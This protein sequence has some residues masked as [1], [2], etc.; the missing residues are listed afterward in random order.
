MQRGAL[1]RPHHRSRSRRHAHPPNGAFAMKRALNEFAGLACSKQAH[2]SVRHDGA[3]GLSM[4]GRLALGYRSLGP[5]RSPRCQVRH[6]ARCGLMHRAAGR[7][8]ARPPKHPNPLMTGCQA[9][10]EAILVPNVRQVF[11]PLEKHL[12]GLVPSRC[13]MSIGPCI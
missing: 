3:S 4:L 10:D 5:G 11:I 12:I 7:S 8:V 9:S 13:G 2:K 6:K 1:T